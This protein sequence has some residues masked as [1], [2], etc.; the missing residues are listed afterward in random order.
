MHVNFQLPI[1]GL[2]KGGSVELSPQLTS[3]H[4]LNCRP[5]CT[6]ENKMRIAQ[7]PAVVK[8]GDGDRPGDTEQPVVQMCVV[9]AVI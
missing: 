8:W 5:R 9:S 6:L 4:M 2:N 1:K 7:R 3:G